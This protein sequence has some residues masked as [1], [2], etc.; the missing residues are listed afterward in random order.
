MCSGGVVDKDLRHYLNL[1]FSKGSVDH[2]HQQI[3]RDNLYLRT[4]PCESTSPSSLL[5]SGLQCFSHSSLVCSYPLPHCVSVI[6][7]FIVFLPFLYSVFPS[8]LLLQVNFVLFLC[9]S[10]HSLPSGRWPRIFSSHTR[11]FSPSLAVYRSFFSLNRPAA[12]L[13]A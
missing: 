6:V 3:I 8:L 4:V 12:E 1:R 7:I 9:F 11:S 10:F 13:S 5:P 2:D